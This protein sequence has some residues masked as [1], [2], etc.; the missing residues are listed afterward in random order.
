MMVRSSSTTQS[1]S[2]SIWGLWDDTDDTDREAG[3]F[4]FCR[5]MMILNGKL[6]GLWW[7]DIDRETEGL[8]VVVG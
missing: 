2:K 4:V 3:W 1:I 7:D 8:L 6:K 5:M